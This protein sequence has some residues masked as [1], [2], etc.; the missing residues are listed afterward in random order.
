MPKL[1]CTFGCCGFGKG[2][3]AETIPRSGK[4]FV[5]GSGSRPG[6]GGG[7]DPDS[8]PSGPQR[9]PAPHRPFPIRSLRVST[10][11]EPVSAAQLAGGSQRCVAWLSLSTWQPEQS[12]SL[13][14]EGPPFAVR[15]HEER[16]PERDWSCRRVS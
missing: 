1:R 16:K 8:G 5:E 11:G 12:G 10:P 6:I 13:G 4:G 7:R 15:G 14:K 2:S 9:C 3:L